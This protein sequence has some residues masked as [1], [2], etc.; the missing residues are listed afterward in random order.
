MLK[1]IG[2]GGHFGTLMI[3]GSTRDAGGEHSAHKDAIRLPNRTSRFP[4]GPPSL[5]ERS[6]GA[7]RLSPQVHGRLCVA[8]FGPV[9]THWGL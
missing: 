6:G 2:L 7:G 1:P 4:V 8:G 5:L 9:P 3:F